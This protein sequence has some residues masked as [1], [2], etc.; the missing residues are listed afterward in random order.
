MVNVGIPSKASS[1][2]Q[3]LAHHT[4]YMAVDL[5]DTFRRQSIRGKMEEKDSGRCQERPASRLHSNAEATGN[6]GTSS[7]HGVH[8]PTVRGGLVMMTM[9]TKPWVQI[10]CRPPRESRG[11]LERLN[12]I[13]R[14][15][16]NWSSTPFALR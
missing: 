11:R 10:D 5:I 16:V 13:I 8:G 6:R 2:T 4:A 9:M 12:V 14:C 7:S 3:S 1:A 15:K